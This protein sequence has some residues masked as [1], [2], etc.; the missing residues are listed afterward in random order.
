MPDTAKSAGAADGPVFLPDAAV[1][2]R[3]PSIDA[4]RLTDE[5]LDV[6]RRHADRAE[7]DPFANPVQL[8]ALDV[9]RRL[10]DGRLDYAALEQLV[11]FLTVDG[12][13]DRARRLGSY[14]GETDPAANEERLRTV[15]RRLAEPRGPEET[16]AETTDRV[17][18]DVFRARVE[19]ELF[20]IVFTGHPTF[21]LSGRLMHALSSLAADR[22]DAG[23]PLDEAGRARLIDL[24]RRGD[25]RPDQPLDLDREHDLSLEAIANAQAALRRAYDILLAVAGELYPERWTELV[26]RLMTIASWVGYDLDGRSDIGWTM[27][28]NKRMRVQHRQVLYYLDEVRSLRAA[29]RGGAA[30]LEDVLELMES[31]LALAANQLGDEVEVFSTVDPNAPDGPDRLARTARRMWDG[32]EMRLTDAGALIDMAGRAIARVAE[33][34]P[35]EAKAKKKAAEADRL[36]RRLSVLRAELANLG[37]GMA[38]THLRVNAAQVHNAIRQSI[39]LVSTPGDPRY[40]QSYLDTVNQ[41]LEEVEPVRINFG[42][43]LAERTSVKQM[44]MVV[45]QMLKYTGRTAPIRFLIAETESAF[46][47][48]VALYFAKLYGVDDRVDLSPLFE[49]EK[50]L[51]AG[52]RVVDQ[53]LNNRH[54]RA[55]IEKRG[56]LCVQTGYSDAGR[57]IGQTPANASIER[58]RLRLIRVMGKHGLSHVQLLVFDTHG[59]SIGRGSHPESLEQRLANIDTPATRGFVAEQGLAFKQEMSFQGGDGYLPFVNRT[60]AFATVTRLIEHMLE[61]GHSSAADPFYDEDAYIREFFTT[62]KEFQVGLMEDRDYG[63][64]LGGFGVNLLFPSGS[65]A[66]KRQHEDPSDIDHASARQL[67]AIPHNAVLQQLGLLANSISGVGQA[68]AKEPDR[69]RDLHAR[70]PRLRQLMG[71][72][73]YGLAVSD[74]RAMQA[75]VAAV[76]PGFWISR[77]GHVDDP[78]RRENMLKLAD[79]HEQSRVAAHQIRVYRKLFRDW[80]VLREELGRVPAEGRPCGALVDARCKESL[81]LLHAVRIAI[82]QEIF[83]LAVRTPEFSS[84]HGTSPAEM[85]ARL[86]HLD[87]DSVCAQLEEIFPLIESTVDIEAFGEPADLQAGQEQSYRF[88]NE[89]LFRPMEGLSALVKRISTAVT[90]R[91][92]F[93]G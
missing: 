48:L 23:D 14:V 87:V 52:S 71:I 89:N 59:E 85:I 76:D 37:L 57:F 51:E 32:M 8:L 80:I 83:L 82:I 10:A 47:C 35:T 50:A 41:L 19:G 91:I 42:S 86:L 30:G 54:Y 72:V 78:E 29:A 18:F 75:Y 5:L 36:I 93:F 81:N 24:A 1:F 3:G 63:V 4:E 45:A 56:R 77:S 62:V 16:G 9:S 69:F 74:P 33:A 65:R 40:R 27:T 7:D 73:E 17:R 34:R 43:V 88:E 70:S 64:L 31:R 20:G 21:N 84:R 92:G 6:L 49:T 55:Y 58:L 61:T 11:Q 79:Y 26:P 12:F 25:H 39:G 2:A 90:H 28:L 53:L 13:L 60:M 68:I 66:L 22:D 15:F 46:T 67:R 44:F 38:H